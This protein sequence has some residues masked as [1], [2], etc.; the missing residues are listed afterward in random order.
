[1]PWTAQNQ[2][3]AET[4]AAAYQTGFATKMADWQNAIRSGKPIHGTE[5]A[6]LKEYIR[7]WQQSLEHLKSQSDAITSNDSVMD[8]LGQLVTRLADDKVLFDQLSAEAG[9][10]TDQA[11]SVNPKIRASPYTNMLGLQRIFRQ[12]TQTGILIASIIFGILALAIL[13]YIV[14]IVQVTGAVVRASPIVG[15]SRIKGT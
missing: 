1:M 2:Q 11:D 15:G 13:G 5:Y 6:A 4:E 9:T 10:R 12:S 3:Q 7:Q 14:Y 8:E